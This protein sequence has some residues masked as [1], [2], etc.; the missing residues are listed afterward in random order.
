V[1]HQETT[2]EVFDFSAM[3]DTEDNLFLNTASKSRWL[4]TTSVAGVAGALVIGA[5]L[6]GTFGLGG[7]EGPAIAAQHS[8][9]IW[10]Q[11]S[12]NRKGD[13]AHGLSGIIGHSQ[14]AEVIAERAYKIH[15]VKFNQA[16]SQSRIAANTAPTG[17]V[18]SLAPDYPLRKRSATRSLAPTPGKPV[19][20]NNQT[21]DIQLTSL[22]PRVRGSSR[23]IF[24]PRLIMR[25]ER[26][27]TPVSPT[28]LTSS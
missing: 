23:W 5:A 2:R 16:K 8:A 4:I 17:L 24:Q 6:I 13:R 9:S 25:L 14:V 22:S 26:A 18:G 20:L 15:S 7:I 28:F 12:S 21:A 27:R 3:D 11:A 19:V 10:Q 1:A